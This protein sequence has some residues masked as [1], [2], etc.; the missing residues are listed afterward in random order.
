MV[1]GQAGRV[2]EPD[3][4]SPSEIFTPAFTWIRSPCI[5]TSTRTTKLTRCDD[6][7]SRP[8]TTSSRVF[9]GRSSSPATYGIR[10]FKPGWTRSYY[11]LTTAVPTKASEN[12]LTFSPA[13]KTSRTASVSFT[14]SSSK[15][16]TAMICYIPCIL[17]TPYDIYPSF[18]YESLWELDEDSCDIIRVQVG[19]GSAV[20]KP[21]LYRC[22]FSHIR[23]Y[24]G[25]TDD[26]PGDPRA[27]VTI[28][29]PRNKLAFFGKGNGSLTGATP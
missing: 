11:P 15:Q 17:R 24:Y 28:P 2:T 18:D 23:P 20:N 9:T 7:C 27:I 26:T 12:G 1:A 16:D 29:G 19:S 22:V 3:P 10:F 4:D 5:I 8:P 6:R 13:M 21:R 14:K 25:K